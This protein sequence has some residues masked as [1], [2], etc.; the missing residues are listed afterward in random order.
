MSLICIRLIK[1]DGGTGPLMS[2]QPWNCKVLN[3][4]PKWRK[5]SEIHTISQIFFVRSC[6]NYETENRTYSKT[7]DTSP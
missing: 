7:E 3:P 1:K 2:W 4:T 5:M 6:K